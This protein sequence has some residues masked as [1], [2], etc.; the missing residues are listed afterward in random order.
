MELPELPPKHN[1]NHLFNKRYTIK[2][3]P[4]ERIPT[5]VRTTN[6]KRNPRP[7]ASDLQYFFPAPDNI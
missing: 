5:F 1:L 3:L 6:N 7:R 4:E 2:P